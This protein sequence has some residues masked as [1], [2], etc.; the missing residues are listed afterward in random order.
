MHCLSGIIELHFSLSL[1]LLVMNHD[2]KSTMMHLQELLKKK[3]EEEELHDVH[4]IP[5]VNRESHPPFL[6]QERC[7]SSIDYSSCLTDR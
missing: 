5:H 3:K 6:L 1:T 7:S 4:S 2:R